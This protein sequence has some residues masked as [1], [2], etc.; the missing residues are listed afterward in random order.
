[1]PYIYRPQTT[2]S[3]GKHLY[4]KPTVN[5]QQTAIVVGNSDPI[6]TDRDH[7]IKIQY[8]WQRGDQS[9]SRLS[10]PY[11]DDHTTA[12]GNYNFFKKMETKK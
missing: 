6:H 3:Q 7:R 4:P 8:H 9:H 11:A 2:D 1:L 12:P 5:G 10:H